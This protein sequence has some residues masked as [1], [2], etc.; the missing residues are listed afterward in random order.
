MLL[1][2]EYPSHEEGTLQ[3]GSNVFIIYWRETMTVNHCI[4][5][6]LSISKYIPDHNYVLGA[7][8]SPFDPELFVDISGNS[9]GLDCK[10][11]SSLCFSSS[12]WTDQ[13]NRS[14]PKQSQ[15]SDISFYLSF[16][17]SQFTQIIHPEQRCPSLAVLAAHNFIVF[18][19]TGDE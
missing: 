14:R 1:L 11:H 13:R 15:G 6:T 2:M 19:S 3:Q 9:S 5:Q 16:S 18:L 12:H 7:Q 8:I 4:F 10:Q 17:P